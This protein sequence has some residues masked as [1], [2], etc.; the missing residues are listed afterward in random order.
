MKALAIVFGLLLILPGLCCLGFGLAFSFS[1][2]GLTEIG[3]VEA[4]VGAL[5]TWGAVALIISGA[6]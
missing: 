2:Y 1:G 4:I 3:I 5:I 6:K